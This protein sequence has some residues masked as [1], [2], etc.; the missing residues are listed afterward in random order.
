MTLKKL[1]L[2]ISKLCKSCKYYLLQ[3]WKGNLT[4]KEGNKLFG[5]YSLGCSQKKISSGKAEVVLFKLH[6]VADNQGRVLH[7]GKFN[8]ILQTYCKTTKTNF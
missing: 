3:N 1:Y 5:R 8:Y 6:S 4:G 7:C 2:Q